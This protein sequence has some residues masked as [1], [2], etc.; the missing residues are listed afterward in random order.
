MVMEICIHSREDM[1]SFSRGFWGLDRDYNS[2]PT[3][4]LSNQIK[5]NFIHQVTHYYKEKT[6]GIV[7]ADHH[8]YRRNSTQR[9]V[10]V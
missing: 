6:Q 7:N 3:L 10:I 1:Y 5:S 8:S 4:I 9:A 2:L